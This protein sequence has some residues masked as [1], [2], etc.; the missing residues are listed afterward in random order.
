MTKK[1]VMIVFAGIVVFSLGLSPGVYLVKDEV[2][3]EWS[4]AKVNA[5]ISERATAATF[6]NADHLNEVTNLTSIFMQGEPVE[7]QPEIGD[8]QPDYA[9]NWNDPSRKVRVFT[10]YVWFTEEGG[11]YA[12]RPSDES[13]EP[14]CKVLNQM[15]ADFLKKM[16]IE[17]A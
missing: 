15:N 16:A 2:T 8:A 10:F 17:G 1:M 7:A 13:D 9:L 5:E 14:R 4:F 12:I 3:A 11:V 6:T